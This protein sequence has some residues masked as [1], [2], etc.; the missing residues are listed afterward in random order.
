MKTAEERQAL[1]I[2]R[3]Q[4]DGRGEAEEQTNNE[5]DQDQEKRADNE[6]TKEE[7]AQLEEADPSVRAAILGKGNEREEID[8]SAE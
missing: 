4:E 1:W 3:D 2:D 5:H 6:V 7:R 8:R